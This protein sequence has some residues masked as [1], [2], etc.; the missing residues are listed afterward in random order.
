M[1]N[2]RL[3]LRGAGRGTIGLTVLCWSR[4]PGKRANI[5]GLS[6][7]ILGSRRNPRKTES[8]GGLGLGLGLGL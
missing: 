5:P 7:Y 1:N 2:T 4:Y 6:S 3:N 8:P